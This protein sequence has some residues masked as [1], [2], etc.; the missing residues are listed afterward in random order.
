MKHQKLTAPYYCVPEIVE[1]DNGLDDRTL[2][3]LCGNTGRPNVPSD[4]HNDDQP[5][6]TLPLERWRD[7]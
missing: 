7:R 3:S 2:A 4:G 5:Y 6:L 1:Y